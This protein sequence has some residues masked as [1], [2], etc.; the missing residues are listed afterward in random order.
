MATP[1]QLSGEKL[2]AYRVLASGLDRTTGPGDLA[3]LDLGVQDRD[4]SAPIALHARVSGDV[5]GIGEPHEDSGLVQLWSLRGSPHVHRRSAARELAGVLAPISEA[6]A[7]ARLVGSGKALQA[8]DVAA[9]DALDRTAAAMREATGSPIVKGALSAA[10]TRALPDSMSGHCTGCGTVHVLEML[11]RS[12]AL[13]AGLGLVPGTKPVVLER[14]PGRRPSVN[15][16][17]PGNYL[18]AWYRLYG[19]AGVAE[20][21]AHLGSTATALKPALP[22]LVPATVS[23]GAT[24]TTA[25]LAEAIDSVEPDRISDLVRLLPPGDPLLATR[26]RKL[27]TDNAAL[28]K[29]LWPALG[30]AGAVLAHGQLAGSWRPRRKATSLTIEVTTVRTLG[31]A[32]RAALQV[33]AEGIGALRG[34]DNTTLLYVT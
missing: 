34:A 32:Q 30:P 17:G 22:D 4:G 3:V 1:I 33:E 9:L 18:T 11:F 6:D 7:L 2:F 20:A 5:P 26:D 19:A 16:D 14:L 8:N 10:V 12:A 15:G 23:G 29:S 25:E 27:L 24:R 21:A 28:T 13:P 31:R